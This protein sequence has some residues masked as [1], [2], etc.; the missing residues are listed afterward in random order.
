MSNNVIPI[1]PA[2]RP[3]NGTEGECFF[4]AWCRFCARDK[5]MSEGKNYDECDDNEVC[6]IIAD[7]FAYDVDDPKYPKEWIV[8]SDG[9]T[10]TAFIQAGQPIPL[11]DE[12]TID[13]FEVQP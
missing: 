12:L 10:C 13:M 4:E 7:T 3:S 6:Q 8:K 11:R 5:A 2:Y 1:F 9:P